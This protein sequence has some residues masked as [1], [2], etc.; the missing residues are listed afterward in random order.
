VMLKVYFCNVLFVFGSGTLNYKKK[1]SLHR[2]KMVC[3]TKFLQYLLSVFRLYRF[4]A[5]DK[6]RAVIN[7]D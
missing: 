5:D 1:S 7:Q 3:L 4:K 2:E 6:L